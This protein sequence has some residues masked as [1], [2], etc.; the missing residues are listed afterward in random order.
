M[1]QVISAALNETEDLMSKY[2][3]SVVLFISK[4]KR[5]KL[6]LATTKNT[7]LVNIMKLSGEYKIKSAELTRYEKFV[8]RRLSL[9]DADT[10]QYTDMKKKY[11]EVTR[12]LESLSFQIDIKGRDLI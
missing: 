3:S 5:T 8:K 2:R 7:E 10:Q 11:K 12:M 4:L 9:V 6:Q 1:L